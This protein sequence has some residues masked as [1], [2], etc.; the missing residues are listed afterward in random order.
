MET[1]ELLKIANIIKVFNFVC[2]THKF[3]PRMADVQ[4]DYLI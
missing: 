1:E 2:Y 4:T 3:L